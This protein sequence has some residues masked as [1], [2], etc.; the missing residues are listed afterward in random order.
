MS[1]RRR[2]RRSP[3]R[4]AS[5]SPSSSVRQPI[6]GDRRGD[7]GDV[8]ARRTLQRPAQIAQ[9]R[10]LVSAGRAAGEMPLDRLPRRR[11]ESIVQIVGK[12]VAHITVR[13]V[14]H[15]ETP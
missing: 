8:D 6:R 4:C 7:G 15:R 11:L 10:E 1:R 9:E 5:R 2:S 14:N 3:R 13:A 12:Q